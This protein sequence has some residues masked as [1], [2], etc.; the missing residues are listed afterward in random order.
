MMKLNIQK[1]TDPTEVTPIKMTGF[2][3]AVDFAATA[4]TADTADGKEEFS[5]EVKAP[6]PILYLENG[7]DADGEGFTCVVKKGIFPFAQEKSF[8]V[9]Y[10]DKVLIELEEG[11]NESTGGI[12]IIELT[13]ET[14][15]KLL[16]D[17]V[18]KVGVIETL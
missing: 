3:T 13:P 5:L 4:A 15:K 18:A 14:G 17:C 12:I 11:Y 16:T 7:G 1:F 10:G 9:D 6:R 2:N 8:F